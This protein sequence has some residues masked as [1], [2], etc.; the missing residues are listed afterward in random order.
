M[1]GVLGLD[2]LRYSSNILQTP[3][4]VKRIWHCFQKNGKKHFK[5]I[6]FY[7]NYIVVFGHYPTVKIQ[8]MIHAFTSILKQFCNIELKQLTCGQNKSMTDWINNNEKK[9]IAKDI[10]Y[11]P[12]IRPLIHNLSKFLIQ[13][14]Q[15]AELIRLC[16]TIKRRK[17][18]LKQCCIQQ[19]IFV[20]SVLLERNQLAMEA[21]AGDYH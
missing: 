2:F 19:I 11:L 14:L 13:A 1:D 12:Y 9:L 8:S 7:I 21:E 20:F 10:V 17:Y 15:L 5:F 6:L 16:A 4:K 3:E 18:K